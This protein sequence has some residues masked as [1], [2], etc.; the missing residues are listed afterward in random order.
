LFDLEGMYFMDSSLECADS[1]LVSTLDVH[2]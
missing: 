2:K 1:H